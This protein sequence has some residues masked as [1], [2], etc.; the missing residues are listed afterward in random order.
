[1][2][3]SCESSYRSNNLKISYFI[4]QKNL[5]FFSFFLRSNESVK[6]FFFSFKYSNLC[7]CGSIGTLWKKQ[8]HCCIKEFVKSSWNRAVYLI[9][10]SFFSHFSHSTRNF[11]L[12][13][14][15]LLSQ[16]KH[17]PSSTSYPRLQTIYIQKSAM[18]KLYWETFFSCALKV[19]HKLR[20]KHAN[21]QTKTIPSRM[22]HTDA[23]SMGLFPLCTFTDSYDFDMHMWKHSNGFFFFFFSTALHESHKTRKAVTIISPAY[24]H[25]H[26]HTL[27]AHSA[28]ATE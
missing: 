5:L 9:D 23:F 7:G 10:F 11:M 22:V 17:S 28:H 21:P 1:M 3:T 13:I 4:S 12:S 6:P 14:S 24:V 18:F 16:P 25:T 15:E 20:K 26:K 8:I 19:M 2:R 27:T